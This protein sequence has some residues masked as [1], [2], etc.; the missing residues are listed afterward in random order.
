MNISA[1]GFSVHFT[2]CLLCVICQRQ[3][4][5]AAAAALSLNLSDGQQPAWRSGL[6]LIRLESVPN[7]TRCRPPLGDLAGPGRH[8]C[9]IYSLCEAHSSCSTTVPCGRSGG[10]QE[11]CTSPATLIPKEMLTQPGNLWDSGEQV[12]CSPYCYLPTVLV[13]Y[14]LWEKVHR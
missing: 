6:C 3:L 9:C 4:I 8:Q 1:L 7:L 13:A 2:F 14:V 12:P 11:L 5:R 10:I